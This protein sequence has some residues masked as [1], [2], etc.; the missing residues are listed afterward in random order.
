LKR[1]SLSVL[2]MLSLALEAVIAYSILY[3]YPYQRDT[4]LMRG[5]ITQ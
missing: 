3:V 2:A 5:R 4:K 1:I